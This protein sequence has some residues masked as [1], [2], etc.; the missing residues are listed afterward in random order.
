MARGLSRLTGRGG[1]PIKF[2]HLPGPGA[3]VVTDDKGLARRCRQLS[4][5]AVV[6]TAGQ[7][8]SWLS[9]QLPGEEELKGDAESQD[10]D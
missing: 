6:L 4:Q 2:A 5:P 3:L 1:D 10:I 7:L 9:Q 8:A